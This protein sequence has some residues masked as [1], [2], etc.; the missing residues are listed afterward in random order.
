MKRTIIQ[1]P[2][3]EADLADYYTYIARDKIQPAERLLVAA[4]EAFERLAE[5][6]M[7]G[8]RFVAKRPEI[9]DMYYCPMPSP[10][11]NYLIFYRFDDQ[12]LDVIR[13]LHGALDLHKALRES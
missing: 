3:A 11:R 5:Y 1:S 8:T 4:H 9:A 10:Y 6:P 12:T 2:Q 7:I 13:V